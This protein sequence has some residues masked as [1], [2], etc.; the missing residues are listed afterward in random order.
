MGNVNMEASQINDR[1]G[2]SKM[3][4]AQHLKALDAIAQQIE[5]M[6]AYT[7]SDRAWLDEWEN[8]L[9]ELPPDPETDG[10]KVLTATT[11]SGETVKSWEDSASG[12]VNYS[13]TEQNTGIK[14]IDNKD[15]YI[16][17]FSLA[18]TDFTKS[19][20]WFWRKDIESLITGYETIV[21]IY[22]DAM[23]EFDGSKH[24][25]PFGSEVYF[26][27]NSDKCIKFANY[28]RNIVIKG[29]PYNDN[30]VN[31]DTKSLAIEKCNIT[32]S[33]TKTTA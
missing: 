5:D 25:L 7:S 30:D 32:V 6:P 9:P 20:N 24:L 8:K 23:I 4:V 19:N 14:W 26:N 16:K 12:G 21:D 22:G 33:Y 13:T 10:V 29:Y 2:S 3:S 31:F 15:I 11:T 1:T 18:E 28:Y 27:D 17:T